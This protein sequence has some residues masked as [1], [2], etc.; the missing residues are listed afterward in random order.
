M[1]TDLGNGNLMLENQVAAVAHFH[2][3]VKVVSF[4]FSGYSS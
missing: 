4:R 3:M 2:L 1:V